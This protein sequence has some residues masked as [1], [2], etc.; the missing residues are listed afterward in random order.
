MFIK[1]R[2]EYVSGNLFNCMERILCW[3]AQ[4][5]FDL[6]TNYTMYTQSAFVNFK[7]TRPCDTTIARSFFFFSVN[8]ISVINFSR[9]QR[10]KI[11]VIKSFV[12]LFV[13]TLSCKLDLHHVT[14]T[15]DVRPIVFRLYINAV[16]LSESV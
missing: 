12:E 9:L 1:T 6:F 14:S 5:S 11:W 7:I 13:Q 3:L 8:C 16:L 4:A 2:M 10:I 15:T